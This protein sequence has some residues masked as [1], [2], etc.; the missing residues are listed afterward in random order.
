MLSTTGR[1]FDKDYLRRA[2]RGTREFQL[3]HGARIYAGAVFELEFPHLL[4]PIVEAIVVP[5]VPGVLISPKVAPRP[6]KSRVA[7]IV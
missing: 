3:R 1:P 6:A 2:V 5:I 7:E 4:M